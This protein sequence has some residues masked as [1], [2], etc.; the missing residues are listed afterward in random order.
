M[1]KASGTIK[2][3]DVRTELGTP[4][5]IGLAGSPARTVAG[6]ASGA[7]KLSNFYNKYALLPQ[8]E[9]YIYDNTTAFNAFLSSA[10]PPTPQSVF[11]TWGRFAANTWFPSGTTPTGEATAWLYN[12]T[13]SRIECTLNTSGMVGFVSIE[14]LDNYIL[15]A[16]L[17]STNGDDDVVGLVA[18]FKNGGTNN[19]AVLVVRTND[20]V[21]PNW[22]IRLQN[23][24]TISTLVS[25]ASAVTAGF[26]TAQSLGGWAASGTTKVK[27]QRSGNM[28]YA[29]CSQF[30]QTAYNETTLIQFDLNSN[31]TTQ[32]LLGKQSYGYCAHSQFAAYFSG[33]TLT[34][35]L[36]MD[37]A[38][39]TVT[40]AVMKFNTTTSVWEAQAGTIAATLGYPR[41]VVNPNTGFT[42]FISPT[43]V[44]T[45]V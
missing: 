1:I 35:T 38:Y 40:G 10:V 28:I 31:T 8:I 43:G 44:I 19:L 22:A 24:A 9:A 17:G 33:T 25:G 26:P 11:D 34:G 37:K 41:Y 3:S 29:T 30:G 4:G 27:V 13:L 2:L 15:E 36:A 14:K 39:N 16:T 32:A 21:A 18:A 7:I 23:A 20:G 5:S 42:F 6:I 12:T 45:K